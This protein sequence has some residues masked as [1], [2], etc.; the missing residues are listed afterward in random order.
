[1]EAAMSRNLNSLPS[2]VERIDSI[3]AS[4]SEREAAKREM[5]DAELVA[6]LLCRAGT[7]LRFAGELLS[8]LLL[9]Q[10]R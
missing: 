8:K 1:M 9:Q 5:R 4:R 3:G 6:E 7:N 2:M 10:T